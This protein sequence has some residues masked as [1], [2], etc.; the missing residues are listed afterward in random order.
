MK[1]FRKREKE[2]KESE[3]KL[4]KRRTV[5][6][7]KEYM[8]NNNIKVFTITKIHEHMT[9]TRGCKKSKRLDIETEKL[10]LRSKTI[11]R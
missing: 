10:R 11:E 9:E 8:Q 5:I 1:L 3:N 7:T 6:F 4:P 2:Q